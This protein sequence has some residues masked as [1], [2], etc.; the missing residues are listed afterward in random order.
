M[1]RIAFEFTGD[2][3]TIIRKVR[4]HISEA[5]N[6]SVI[7][8]NGRSVAVTDGQKQSSPSPKQAR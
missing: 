6:P 5:V 3:E 4:E 7:D 1:N 8:E 2:A